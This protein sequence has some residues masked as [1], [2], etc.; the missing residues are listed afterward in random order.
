MC[1]KHVLVQVSVTNVASGCHC[2]FRRRTVASSS[3][4]DQLSVLRATVEL[5]FP[6]LL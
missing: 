1:S 5:S 4:G 6:D 3:H 2:S